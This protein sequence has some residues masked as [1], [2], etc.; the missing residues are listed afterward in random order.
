M[1]VNHDPNA[2]AGG[3]F[4]V[5]QL[6]DLL[7]GIVPDHL[8]VA[9]GGNCVWSDG[10]YD[11]VLLNALHHFGHLVFRVQTEGMILESVKVV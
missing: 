1:D 9:N 3:E 7:H 11:T 8:R 2:A 5:A 4:A 10:R 6:P